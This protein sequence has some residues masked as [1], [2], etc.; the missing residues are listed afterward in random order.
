MALLYSVHINVIWFF[1]FKPLLLHVVLE[2]AMRHFV[3]YLSYLLSHLFV[4]WSYLSFM[5]CYCL[6]HFSSVHMC[7]CIWEFCFEWRFEIRDV[8]LFS[9]GS[10]EAAV[11]HNVASGSKKISKWDTP[12]RERRKFIT[13]QSSIIIPF[14]LSSSH[15]INS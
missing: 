11:K 10:A 3:H 8:F 6:V 15:Y 7:L 12:N 9:S 5:S 4:L 13:T 14:S 1:C 2:H